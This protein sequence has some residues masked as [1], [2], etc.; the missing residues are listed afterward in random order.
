M[1]LVEVDWKSTFLWRQ[2]LLDIIIYFILPFFVDEIHGLDIKVD[3]TSDG[4]FGSEDDL[5]SS[6]CPK[7]NVNGIVEL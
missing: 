5:M 1:G 4:D 6:D 7:P 2:F 3:T